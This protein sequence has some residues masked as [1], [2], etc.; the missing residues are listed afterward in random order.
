MTTGGREVA[1]V[2]FHVCCN[3]LAEYKVEFGQDCFV[4]LGLSFGHKG[5]TGS[6]GA[7]WQP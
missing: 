4:P 2:E 3:I 5:R 1:E 7:T 6:D